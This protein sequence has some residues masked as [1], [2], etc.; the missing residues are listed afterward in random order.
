[1]GSSLPKA[2]GVHYKTNRPVVSFNGDQGF[3]MN[4]QELQFIYENKLPIVIVILNNSSSGM[5]RTRQIKGFNSNFLHT[6][7]ES[8][9]SIPDFQ[10]IA[11]GYKIKYCH[12]CDIRDFEKLFND[13]KEPLIIEVSINPEFDLD[14]SIKAGDDCQNMF[15]YLE[16]N[17]YSK[18]DKL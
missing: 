8:G 5:I 18:L 14:P 15:P 1:M 10:R 3:Q 9:Y 11:F 16:K 4:I 13:I 17:L 2:I 7:L 6:T 12:F